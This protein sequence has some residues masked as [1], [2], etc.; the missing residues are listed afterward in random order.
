MITGIVV[1]MYNVHAYPGWISKHQDG[2][3]GLGG[4]ARLRGGVQL[5]PLNPIKPLYNPYITLI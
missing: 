5:G 3:S 1:L 4:L 2:P